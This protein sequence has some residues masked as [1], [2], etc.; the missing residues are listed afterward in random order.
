[1]KLSIAIN[2]IIMILLILNNGLLSQASI[3]NNHIF[4]QKKTYKD[5]LT[6]IRTF[7]SSIDPKLA[8]YYDKNYHNKNA[9]KYQ[10]V[11]FPGRVVRDNYGHPLINTTSIKEYFEKIG[12][13][14]LYTQGSTSIEM[15]TDMQYTVINFLG[16]VGYQFSERDLWDL[17][18]YI[19]YNSEGIPKYYIDINDSNWA[20]GVTSIIMDIPNIGKVEV[21]DVNTWTGNFTGKH[22]IN[23]FRDL[24][25]P[26][27]QEYIALDHFKFKY[28]Q[29]VK[30]LKKYGKTI[31]EY[32]GTKLYWNKC[33][34]IISPPPGGRLN[35]V[36]VT[37]SGL[38]AGAHLRG[39]KGIV[40]LLIN[41]ENHAD[42]IST[43]ILQY[44]QDFGGYETPFKILNFLNVNLS[45]NKTLE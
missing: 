13:D 38:L 22:N 30:E 28:N 32:I 23:N 9:F 6:S 43:T 25:E 44:V 16:F 33:K 10:K 41:H 1:M 4:F 19:N 36:E 39:A 27:K 11:Y 17:G 20:N 42:E 29:I 21:T 15:F 35:E 26:K 24:T 40:L 14:Y 31:D 2:R 34:P 18:Y 8:N 37:M 45:K 7:E 5:F 3:E 12:I